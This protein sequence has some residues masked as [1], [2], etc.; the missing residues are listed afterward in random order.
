MTKEATTT[1]YFD[2]KNSKTLRSSQINQNPVYEFSIIT[3]EDKKIF[4][5][6]IQLLLDLK[7]Q[8]IL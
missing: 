3:H 2:E 1:K 6:N 4:K 7:N 5:E 8:K